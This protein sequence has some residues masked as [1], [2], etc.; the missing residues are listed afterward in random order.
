MA[1]GST[2]HYQILVTR[3]PH[4][5]TEYPWHKT[6]VGISTVHM[7]SKYEKA[8]KAT[9]SEHTKKD[10]LHFLAGNVCVPERKKSGW[11]I[12]VVSFRDLS[13]A[14]LSSS[15]SSSS[16]IM[17]SLIQHFNTYTQNRE[18]TQDSTLR[19]E[20]VEKQLRTKTTLT[21]LILSCYLLVVW[22]ES[23]F[24]QC[25]LHMFADGGKKYE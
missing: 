19:P 5:V 20:R 23:E 18:E 21:H 22:I 3:C 15:S 8:D 17:L 13:A 7:D 12:G 2:E 24:I 4:N 1:A 9:Q 10:K 11:Q 16:S 6:A 14:H 25:T